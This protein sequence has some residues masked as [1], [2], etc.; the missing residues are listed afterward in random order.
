MATTRPMNDAQRRR[1]RA[2]ND[3]VQEYHEAYL[4]AG[5][6]VQASNTA[7]Q[8]LMILLK[9]IST[10]ESDRVVKLTKRI[11]DLQEEMDGLK[12]Q[13]R[14][15]EFTNSSLVKINKAKNAA[16]FETLADEVAAALAKVNADYA[17]VVGVTSSSNWKSLTEFEKEP[18]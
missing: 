4:Q 10:S 9:A 16:V 2:F 15:I 12:E 17:D 1:A 18:V 3:R 5:A 13:L 14:D 8:E 7:Y 6:K 11:Q